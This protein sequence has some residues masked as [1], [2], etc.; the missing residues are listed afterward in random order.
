MGRTDWRWVHVSLAVAALFVL[1]CL[2]T[3]RIPLDEYV[4]TPGPPVSVASL[5]SSPADRTTRADGQILLPDVHATRVSAFGYLFYGIFGHARV[6][7]EATVLGPG[8]PP[9]A[10]SAEGEAQMAESAADAKAAALRRLGYPVPG[11]PAG[12][13]VVAVE[14]G[15][16]AFEH[17]RPGEI[18]TA[19]DGVTTDGTCGFS[20]VL[21]RRRPGQEVVLSV[22]RSRVTARGRIVP[23]PTASE[24]LRLAPLPR[25]L[26][27]SSGAPAALTGCHR[28]AGTSR[29][30]YL[31]VLG[32]DHEEFSFPLAVSV[33]TTGTE[34]SS[35]GLAMALGIVDLLSGGRLTGGKA[36][37]AAGTVA[38]TGQVGPVGGVR[39]DALSADRARATVLIVPAAQVPT[40]RRV[41]TSSLRVVGVRSLTQALGTLRRLGA[42][43]RAAAPRRRELGAPPALQQSIP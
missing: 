5:I 42:P 36:V 27:A 30:G 13:L 12:V 29:G 18:V 37:A 16:P 4:L 41:A 25:S 11:R 10:L 43:V 31:G 1:A 34:G 40:A 19:V 15:S 8:I 6:V 17:L 20:R 23:G 7:P 24:H 9:S 39:E 33:R 3:S 32:I 35:A 14:P 22:E 2:I 38:P 26:A 21:S 28:R